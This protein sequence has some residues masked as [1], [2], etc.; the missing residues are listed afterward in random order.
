MLQHCKKF[1]LYINFKTNKKTYIFQMDDGVSTEQR[2]TI[3]SCFIFHVL[4][5]KYGSKICIHSIGKPINFRFTSTK[6]HNFVYK[7]F[8]F[9]IIKGII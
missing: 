7:I 3:S 6:I 8:L 1:I 4:V 9:F 2:K 5:D